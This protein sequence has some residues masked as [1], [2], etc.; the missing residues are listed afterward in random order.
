MESTEL[1]TVLLGVTS[2]WSVERVDMDIGRQEVRVYVAHPPRTRFACPH[3]ERELAVFDH[4]AERQW[5][6]LDSCQFM[7]FLAA[8]PPRVK[9][10]EHGKVQVALPWAQP[11]GRFT[12]LFEA[13]AIDVLLA[14]NVKR[15]AE[16]L[17]LSWDEAWAVEQRA[18]ERGQARKARR[19]PRWLG[20]DEK[21]IAKG[22]KYMTLACDLE[23]GTIE[24]VGE[25]REQASLASY[26]ARFEPQELS[27]IEAVGMDMWVPYIQATQ[28]AVPG[29][30]DKIVFDRFHIAQ[31]CA[32][33][34]DQTR[35]AENKQLRAQGDERLVRTR[36]VWLHAEDTVPA[37]AAAAFD[38]LKSST[39]KTARAW[40]L[41]ES[42]RLLWTFE[43]RAD[44]EPFWRWWYFWATHSRLPPIIE[45]AR[46]I[47]RHVHNVLTYFT[48][49]ITNAV[50]EGLNS[51]IAG[52]QKR[53]CGY[54]NR[55]HFKTA[56]Y[57]HCG[58]LDLYP[59]RWT[60]KEV[61]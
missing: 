41:K 36:Y 4:Q 47:Q 51:K 53:A 34:V 28:A 49:R 55:D 12:N 52:I 17:R 21:A 44:A 43:Q 10:P 38:A 14:T 39:L 59:S 31:Q 61:G 19:V 50:A 6:H 24:Y 20:V 30:A 42:L 29:A 25:G 56:I 5:R 26:Y 54:R 46:T 60:P 33:A 27:E 18:V 15:A 11:H 9:C 32:R 45:V 35:R 3:C 8:R 22:H 7:T 13:L 48:H 16:L 2:P 40:A 57:F 37:S 23:A 1:Y 58:G